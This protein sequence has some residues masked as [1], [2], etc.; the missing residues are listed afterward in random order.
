VLATQPRD[1]RASLS[2]EQQQRERQ[3][4]LCSDGVTFLELADL[5]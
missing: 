1:I 5:I 4:G 3:P 2:R